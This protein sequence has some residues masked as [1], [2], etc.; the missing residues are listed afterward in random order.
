MVFMA[1]LAWLPRRAIAAI[2]IALIVLHNTTLFDSMNENA[3]ASSTR[4]SC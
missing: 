3:R 4:R 1:A 2:G